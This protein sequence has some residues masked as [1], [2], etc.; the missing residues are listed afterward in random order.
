MPRIILGILVLLG[1]FGGT[2]WVSAQQAAK[3]QTALFLQNSPAVEQTT[4]ESMTV[5]SATFATQLISATTL[6]DSRLELAQLDQQAE[7]LAQQLRKNPTDAARLAELKKLLEQGFEKRQALQKSEVETLRGRLARVEALLKKREEKKNEIIN[8]RLNQ[9]RGESDDLEWNLSDTRTAGNRFDV[10]TIDSV[11]RPEMYMTPLQ[12]PYPQ[13]TPVPQDIPVPLVTPGIPYTEPQLPPGARGIPE[14][15][16]G[17]PDVTL[18]VPVRT[19]PGDLNQPR[20]E[21]DTRLLEIAVE[22]AQAELEHV[23]ARHNAMKKSAPGSISQRDVDQIALEVK[24]KELELQ[25]AQRRLL[26]RRIESVELIEPLR[27]DPRNRIAPHH[28]RWGSNHPPAIDNGRPV[29]ER[30]IS[31]GLIVNN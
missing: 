22:L 17:Q 12:S 16:S 14:T 20:E 26:N 24:R 4:N 31:L 30:K 27:G 10:V 2:Y 3:M 19:I 23:Q 6:A 18:P 7:L 11:P 15:G 13:A 29:F 5:T 8:R 9:L 1:I 21:A 25:A 28:F